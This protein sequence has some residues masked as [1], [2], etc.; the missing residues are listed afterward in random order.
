MWRAKYLTW[1]IRV[2]DPVRTSGDSRLQA[3][4]EG[5]PF[6]SYSAAKERLAQGPGV[7]A[8]ASSVVSFDLGLIWVST[9]APQNPSEG[10]KSTTISGPVRR[11]PDRNLLTWRSNQS[12]VAYSSRSQK[13]NNTC[14]P[15]PAS[16]SPLPGDSN[17]TPIY[18]ASTGRPT[19]LV[20][21]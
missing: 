8:P 19:R 20:P 21:L 13:R 1:G 17:G 12:P 6:M 14:T 10:C 5:R 11:A 3:Q 16:P 7:G 9:S 15:N 4:A 2:D 18:S